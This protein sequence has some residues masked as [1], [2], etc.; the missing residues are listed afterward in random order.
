MV[1]KHAGLDISDDAI[2]CIEYSGYAPN[3]VI[4]KYS[5]IEL[6]NGVIEGGEI[7]NELALTENLAKLDKDLGLTYAKVSVPE[8]KS[9]LFQTDV[10]STDPI[11][12]AQNIEFK[13]EENVPLALSEAVFYF[14]LLPMSVTGGKLRASVSVVPKSYIEKIVTL[15]RA[16]GISPIAFEVVPKSI[17]RAILSQ[18]VTDS[19]MVVHVMN[20]K[21]GI[22]VISG[23]VVC[24]TSTISWGDKSDP[25]EVAIT[26]L[27]EE[28]ARVNSYWTSHHSEASKLGQVILVGKN[29]SNYESVISEYLAKENLM[30]SIGNVW[31]NAFS[32]DNYIPP[33]VK[34]QSLEYVVSA[35]LAMD[36]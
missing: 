2:R 3:F 30:V 35:G 36:L 33:I 27:L 32:L 8:E 31:T 26:T 22:Y 15:L 5:V 34:E 21:T 29:S 10:S 28:L 17:A 7:K 16:S 13:L 6:P 11:A 14:D 9:Y 23:G 25:K 1:M 20:K 19:V 12:N 18:S 4:N 24:F